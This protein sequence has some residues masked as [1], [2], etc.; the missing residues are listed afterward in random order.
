[1][2]NIIDNVAIKID[3]DTSLFDKKLKSIKDEFKKI[4]RIQ[5]DINK[6]SNGG[7][8]GGSLLGAAAL[9]GLGATA[10][11]GRGGSLGSTTT[12]NYN[13]QQIEKAAEGTKKLKSETVSL[14][15]V[16]E[17]LTSKMRELSNL[18]VMVSSKYRI[19]TEDLKKNLKA[20]LATNPDSVID[21]MN[22]VKDVFKA[23]AASS[24]IYR[25]E[26]KALA[27]QALPSLKSI[28]GSK[29]PLIQKSGLNKVAGTTASSIE[30]GKVKN[31]NALAKQIKSIEERALKADKALARMKARAAELSRIKIQLKANWAEFVAKTK[32]AFNKINVAG[33]RFVTGLA[34]GLVGG[35]AKA[36]RIVRNIALA[37]FATISILAKKGFEEGMADKRS[38]ANLDAALAA[39]G[40]TIGVDVEKA[41]QLIDVLDKETNFG[42]A[43]LA[44]ASAILATFTNIK[45]DKFEEV[46]GVATD[47]SAAFGQDLKSSA[48]QLGK[49]LNDPI[50]GVTALSR[51]GVSFTEQ[52]KAKIKA[53]TEENKILEAQEL[54]LNSLRTQGIS[55]QAKAMA[56]SVAQTKKG[57]EDFRK[58]I[59]TMVVKLFN[60]KT[61]FENGRGWFDSISAK[62]REFTGSKD[63]ANWSS[64]TIYYLKMVYAFFGSLANGIRNF[65]RLFGVE[66]RTMLGWLK[67][68]VDTMGDWFAYTFGGDEGLE[69]FIIKKNKLEAALNQSLKNPPTLQDIDVKGII[70][71]LEQDMVDLGNATDDTKNKFQ[72][73]KNTISQS[74]GATSIFDSVLDGINALVG[75]SGTKKMLELSKSFPKIAEFFKDGK[76]AAGGLGESGLSTATGTSSQTSIATQIVNAITKQT[77]VL[78]TSLLKIDKSVNSIAFVM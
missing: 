71:T 34:N 47:L 68:F 28:S 76:L 63:F 48:V 15:T 24:A 67:T 11:A 33:G 75:G 3:A 13:Y 17:A 37:A 29:N 59:A 5:V 25:K 22:K 20:Q 9:G 56:D 16:S 36:F 6:N 50:K 2:A 42:K 30:E 39:T 62:I 23:A 69:E 61:V 66:L 27:N 78:N 4:Q 52:E 58:E 73:L 35:F 21:R 38:F 41:K 40:K 1:M 77:D 26:L 49:A 19:L 44:N 54:I 51:V 64:Y 74:T 46:L 65:A 8:G 43:E 14:T 10:L 55:G 70:P 57:F 31:Y 7:A 18:T 12:N 53:L 72:E 45:G 60:L 32:A